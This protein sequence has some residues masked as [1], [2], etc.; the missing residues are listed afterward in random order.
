ME[1]A[2][3]KVFADIGAVTATFALSDQRSMGRQRNAVAIATEYGDRVWYGSVTIRPYHADEIERIAARMESLTAADG[4]F[5][6]CPP[7]RLGAT[8]TAGEVTLI[9][10]NDRRVLRAT[11]AGG[12][13]EGDWIGIVYDGGR[14]GLHQVL[15][16]DGSDI[17]VNP[18][19]PGP[20]TVGDPTT[21]G[22]PTIRARIDQ[23]SYTPPTYQGVTADGLSFSWT[24]DARRA[25]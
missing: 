13:S 20:V 19:L 12:Q 14:R 3:D 7:D 16:R 2:V 18:A 11:N 10:A 22:R 4:T 9:G 15:S 25:P 1:Y 23:G 17:R 21:Y 8:A 6:I 24:Q 5:L